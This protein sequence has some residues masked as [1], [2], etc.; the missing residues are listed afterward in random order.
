[1]LP[2]APEMRAQLEEGIGVLI[3]PTG[4]RPATSTTSTSTTSTTT[5]TSG[6]APASSFH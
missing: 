2:P 6:R 1:M 3:K 5:R 4:V